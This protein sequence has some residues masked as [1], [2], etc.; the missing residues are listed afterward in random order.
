MQLIR[1]AETRGGDIE[2]LKDVPPSHPAKLSPAYSGGSGDTPLVALRYDPW[3]IAW[4]FSFVLAP[5]FS[6]CIYVV[7]FRS[8]GNGDLARLAGHVAGGCV[9]LAVA[10]MIIDMF[11]TKEYLLFPDRIVKSFRILGRIEV[12]LDNV[13]ILPAS[14]IFGTVLILS[15]RYRM[16]F[17]QRIKLPAMMF[18][19]NLAPKGAIESLDQALK[20]IGIKLWPTQG[21]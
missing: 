19:L 2:T 12:Q 6:L 21:D 9:L 1:S 14:Y 13:T 11:F 8:P 3:R 10:I 15:I 20:S 17:P 4:R 7:M 16:A 5:F 18:D